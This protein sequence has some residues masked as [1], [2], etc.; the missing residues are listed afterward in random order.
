MAMVVEVFVHVGFEGSEGIVREVFGA[1]ERLGIPID[2]RVVEV[3]SEDEAARVG[4]AALPMVRVGGRDIEPTAVSS[5]AFEVGLVRGLGARSWCFV[6]EDGA[7]VGALAEA[8]ATDLAAD[9]VEVISV[10]RRAAGGVSSRALESLAEIGV[11]APGLPRAPEAGRVCE[12]IVVLD[13]GPLPEPL[14]GST[15]CVLRWL[16][17][18]A[19]DELAAMRRCRDELQRRLRRLLGRGVSVAPSPPAAPRSAGER[20]VASRV[21]AVSA[22]L[23]LAAGERSAA[24]VY[25]GQ[26]EVIQGLRQETLPAHVFRRALRLSDV[27]ED[28]LW[29]LFVLST[30]PDVRQRALGASFGAGAGVTVGQLGWMMSAVWPRDE[31]MGALG[32]GGLLLERRLVRWARSGREGLPERE[33]VLAGHVMA[34]LAGRRQV[35]VELWPAVRRIEPTWGLEDV[36]VA[37]GFTMTL[38]GVAQNWFHMPEAEWSTQGAGGLGGERGAAVVLRGVEGSGRAFGVRAL[39]GTLKRALLVLDGDMLVQLGP[40]E[41]HRLLSGALAEA[42]CHGEMV[43]VRRADGLM[44]G[45]VRWAV[46]AALEAH[47]ALVVLALNPGSKLSEDVAS[48]VLLELRPVLSGEHVE[49]V[50]RVNVPTWALELTH[51]VLAPLGRYASL[52]P[53]QVRNAARVAAHLSEQ[54]EE[55]PSLERVVDLAVRSQLGRS[56]GGLVSDEASH[57]RLSDLILP[58][59]TRGQVEEIVAAVRNRPRV[60]DHWRLRERLRRGLSITC[61]FDGEPGTGKTLSAEVIASEVGLRL[62]RVNISSIVDKY[63]GETEK[64]LTRLFAQARPDLHLLM[65]DEADSLFSKRSTRIERSTDRYSN[66]DINVLLQLI[67]AFEGVAILTT[68]LKQGIDPAF[69]RRISFKVHFPTPTAAERLLLWRHLFP[70]EWVPTS[71]PIEFE[72]LAAI[73]LTGGSIKNAV[74]KAAYKAARLDCQVDTDLLIDAAIEEARAAGHLVRDRE[75]MP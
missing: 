3:A 9:G 38:L 58:E 11:S 24:L 15:R 40:D 47:R 29:W 74:L 68:N 31:V 42:E 27:E 17:E 22:A 64:N 33:V 21:A 8:L 5:W 43:L 66:M 44:T 62:M 2:V 36:P 70:E 65:F 63:I 55:G 57:A 34:A 45:P 26:R 71:E 39:A 50:W 46:R 10:G 52:T 6:S 53:G 51:D 14:V 60:L 16:L 13:D 12:G 56:L 41:A 69:E 37:D 28:I 61:L 25:D 23:R 32:A 75:S 4:V 73:E 20:L 7:G 19:D 30:R 49:E 1:S 72:R 18:D 54:G 67:E 35:G 48:W 59:T